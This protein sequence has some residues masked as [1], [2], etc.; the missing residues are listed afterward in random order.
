MLFNSTPYLIFLPLVVLAYY[1]L[2]PRYRRIL[3]LGAG[4]YFYASW[5]LPF[6]GLLLGSTALN[7]FLGLRIAG[8]TEAR[9]RKA[10]LVATLAINLSTLCLFKYANWFSNISYHVL[11]F[12]PWQELKW[13]LPLGISFYTFEVISY[14]VD[15]Y[16]G[17]TRPIRSLLD[18]A[19]YIS[20]FPHLIAGPI[21]RAN[22]LMPQLACDRPLDG[23]LLREGIG[24]FIWG[25]FKKI[26]VADVMAH[27]V[28][29]V[30][31]SSASYSGTGLILATY[32]FAVQ[33]YCDFSAYSDMAIGSALMLGIRLPE[34]FDKPYLACGI[35]EFWRRWHISLS[36]WL[37]DY[38]Y[39]P[40][41]GN[42]RGSARTYANLLLTMAL[43]GLWHGAG[44]A[45]VAWGFLHGA[46]MG[47]ERL[48]GL[49]EK[50]PASMGWRWAR[51]LVTLHLIC[52]SWILFRAK[53]LPEAAM[54]LR[55]IFTCAS[56]SLHVGY[57]PAIYLAM[58][59][60][61]ECLDAK[62]R[63]I[64]EFK[65]APAVARWAAYA[66]A[67]LFVLTFGRSGPAEF[68][69]FQF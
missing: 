24:R 69:Y 1:N 11:G 56:G 47:F 59:I 10:W 55:R 37:R 49:G 51:R 53:N 61:V 68:L 48:V 43:G 50:P 67:L 62:R 40:L 9:P 57:A 21:I 25:M 66:S 27:A 35:R 6:L 16:R 18:M 45:W 41:G 58:V 38:L 60:L 2:T 32:A 39:I 52:L 33:I 15:E 64:D 30:Y 17:V 44:W 54:I 8:S 5:S 12:H 36:S 46:A 20:F 3:L 31:G 23:P 63:F 7:Y 26:F 65:R 28:N 19:L 22:D 14:V 4:Y 29:E 42:R 13:A 34:N